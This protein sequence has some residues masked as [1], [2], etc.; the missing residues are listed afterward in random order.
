MRKFL[1]NAA[2]NCVKSFSF[3]KQD[4]LWISFK[5]TY[6]RRKMGNWED[7][8]EM[9]FMKREM[10]SH[11]YI[12]TN[13]HAHTKL[14]LCISQ[15]PKFYEH[16]MQLHLK[17]YHIVGNISFLVG[18]LLLNRVEIPSGKFP[19]INICLRLF[20]GYKILHVN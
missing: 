9:L 17:N 3:T 8:Q 16:S 1:R 13:L 2:Y 5:G 19:V 10:Y 6:F 11:N 14:Y 4:Q 15:I 7:F 20:R 12:Y 18:N